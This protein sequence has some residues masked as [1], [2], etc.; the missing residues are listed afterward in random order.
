MKQQSRI[1]YLCSLRNEIAVMSIVKCRMAHERVIGLADSK[2][3]VSNR[4][5]F[6]NFKR[7]GLCSP[8]VRGERL[9][10]S[11]TMSRTRLDRA[12]GELE[13]GIAEPYREELNWLTNEIHLLDHKKGEAEAKQAREEQEAKKGRDEARGLE[14]VKESEMVKELEQQHDKYV[15]RMGVLRDRV[16]SELD[17]VIAEADQ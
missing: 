12:I 7:V 13:F 11:H 17:K 14:L 4:G 10:C 5:T 2:Q 3:S 16:V 15:E 9:G 1:D 8:E 6:G